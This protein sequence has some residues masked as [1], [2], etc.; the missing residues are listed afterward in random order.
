[1]QAAKKVEPV[2]VAVTRI[3][4]DHSFFAS[5]LLQHPLQADMNVPTACVNQFGE[6]RYNPV[7]LNQLD[8]PEIMFVLCHEC[9]HYMYM[10]CVRRFSRD[11][12]QWN[13]ACD[14]V[15]NETLKA[16]KVGRMP[17]EG[18]EL[19]GAEH[20][21]AEQVYGDMPRQPPGGGDG[22]GNSGD[23]GKPGDQQG[24]GQGQG[25]TTNS[26]GKVDPNNQPTGTHESI[27]NDLNETTE[28]MSE[29]E[30]A[31]LAE[32]VKTRILQA[33]NAA[34]Q[35]G[36][37][38]ALLDQFVDNL[39]AV[40]MPWYDLMRPYFTQLAFDDYTYQKCDR[41]YIHS[42]LYLPAET[43]EG[44]GTVAIITDESGSIGQDEL[45]VMASHVN[46]ICGDVKPKKVAV[47]HCASRTHDIIDEFEPQDYPIQFK[48]R[49]SGGTDMTKGIER[50]VE[51]YP[52]AELIIVFTDGYTPFGDETLAQGIPVIWGITTDKVAP[53]GDTIRVD[54]HS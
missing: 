36:N 29:A 26:G 43:G 14:A 23:G 41:R 25:Q 37:M 54:V 6:I 20:K 11:P 21:T 18:V 31:A 42:A 46:E 15:I 47:I 17:A 28:Q 51:E 9:M 32:E 39:I 49:M 45:A 52:D 3:I 10:H 4:V 27:G 7:W 30:E 16:T 35:S 33:R 24:Q 19:P 53:W 34:K 50:A 22:S 40:H 5:L 8:V 12:V 44:A 1:M 2:D 38:P 48:S 13:I